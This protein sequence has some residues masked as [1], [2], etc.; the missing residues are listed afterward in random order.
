MGMRKNEL[1]Q[2]IACSQ[3]HIPNLKSD[4]GEYFML[5]VINKHAGHEKELKI[6]NIIIC[7]ILPT[8]PYKTEQMPEE[9][10]AAFIRLQD[11]L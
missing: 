2:T 7:D 5:Q 4:T 1:E 11:N 3:I 10:G 6:I 9:K 8:N